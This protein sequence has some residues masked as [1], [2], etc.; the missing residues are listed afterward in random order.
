MG[1]FSM[2]KGKASSAASDASTK[3]VRLENKDLVEAVVFGSVMMAHADGELED[4]E[5]ENLHMQLEGNDIFQGFPQAELGKMIDKACGYYK[6]GSM[7]GNKKCLDELKDVKN[8]SA[9]ADEVM[10]A[11]LTV[12]FADGSFEDKERAVAEK[13]AGILNVRLKDYVDAA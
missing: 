11:V 10:T 3:I 13:L 9:H 1:L 12:A 8:N 2:L 4:S 7:M 5:L 6:M